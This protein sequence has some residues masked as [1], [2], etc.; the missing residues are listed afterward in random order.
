MTNRIQI[1][2]ELESIA[3]TLIN[4]ASVTPYTIPKD[5]FGSFAEVLLNKI[6]TLEVQ[7]E[8]N[9]LAPLLNTISKQ[10]VNHIP[11]N[12]LQNPPQLPVNKIVSINNKRKFSWIKYA[13]AACI[14]GII[15][16]IAFQNK[17]V[18]GGN[19]SQQLTIDIDKELSKVDE[20]TIENYLKN[21][22]SDGMTFQSVKT[23]DIELLLHEF[24][25]TELQQQL[26]YENGIIYNN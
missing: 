23:D 2:K 5:Y 16:I 10:P 12:Y 17:S 24:S 1:T 21:Y 11:D 6:Y 13:V 22:E 20:A 9:D 14:G 3:P 18:V 4:I 19:Q 8:L 26:K 15:S 25:E 7:N